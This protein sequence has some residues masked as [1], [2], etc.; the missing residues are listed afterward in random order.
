MRSEL[1]NLDTADCGRQRITAI[2]GGN[3]AG[4]GGKGMT[5]TKPKGPKFT[6]KTVD[7]STLDG[8]K[9]AERL[10]VNGW[11]TN[12]VGLFLVQFEKRNW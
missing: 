6:Y 12:R 5:T 11:R 4:T 1:G 7:T 10:H 8:L 2:P 9:Q 3:R